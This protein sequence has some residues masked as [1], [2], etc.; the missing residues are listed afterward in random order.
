MRHRVALAAAAALVLLAACGDNPGGSTRPT[1]APAS[2]TASAVGGGSSKE[3]LFAVLEPGGDLTAMRDNTVAIVRPNGTAKAKARFDARQL[4]RVG[5][6][7][8]LPQ[9]EARVAAGRVYFADGAGVVRSLG[10][11]GSIAGVASFPLTGPQQLLSFAVSPDGSQ[12]VAAVLSFPPVHVPLPQTPIDPPFGPGDFSLQMFTAR[13]GQSVVTLSR[14]NWPQSIGL[15]RDVLSIVG[16]SREAPLATIDTSLGTQQGSLGRQMFGH[17]AELDT[18]GRPGPPLGGYS[19]DA[20]SALPDETVLCDDDG[21]LRNFSVRSKDGSVRF[22]VRAA[23]DAQYLDV[24][25]APDASRV[26]YMVAGGRAAVTDAAG[27]SV[28]LPA[29]FRPE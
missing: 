28:Q 23:G 8:P 22:R 14:R 11:D 26:V 10:V 15:P 20:W 9:P 7:L 29:S 6:A 2:P 3:L 16:W 25:L 24:Q 12:L 19:C 1:A 27:R 4:P 17:V 21:Q 13:A 5:N 18:A